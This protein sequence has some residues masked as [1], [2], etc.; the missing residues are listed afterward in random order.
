MDG[1]GDGESS[2]QHYNS[3]LK[4]LKIIPPRLAAARCSPIGSGLNAGGEIFE[5]L[6]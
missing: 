4:S 2:A 1:A 3:P 6:I 5:N